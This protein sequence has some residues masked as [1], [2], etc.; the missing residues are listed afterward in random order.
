MK[1]LDSLIMQ[2]ALESK[3]P[4]GGALAVD[5]VL[6]SQY[7]TEK[8]QQH[9]L[10]EYVVDEVT[11]I[12]QFSN[13]NPVIIASG[14]LTSRPL[15]ES[16]ENFLGQE[17]LAFFDA[18]SPII[19]FDS[20]N[21]DALFKQ[22]R[23]DKG[24]GKD[25]WNIPLD[26]EQYRKFI[27]DINQAEKYSGNEE[28]EKDSL[29]KLRPF[30]GCMP[31]EDMAARGEDTP[32]FGP[33]KPKGLRDPQSGK[34][35]YAVMQLRQDDQE[36]KLWSMVGMQTRMKRHEQQRIF[37]SLPGLEKAEFVRYGTVHRNTF[38]DSPKIISPTLELRK[39][40]G[41]FFAGQITGVEGY[42]ESTASG[43][44]AGINAFRRL[45][46]ANLLVLPKETAIGGLINYV[47]DQ[48]RLH[49]QPMNVSYGLISED[50]LIENKENFKKMKKT[51]KRQLIAN[52]ALSLIHEI[53]EQI[54]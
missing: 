23:Y 50:Y 14:P 2:A 36:G 33:L 54:K 52:R 18:I 35:P 31:I 13:I 8:I 46:G 21:T 32:R 15:A 16:I 5:R 41:L 26:K 40:E 38:I 17:S 51:V 53:K 47:S 24:A 37:C 3:V 12:P 44:V 11:A 1:I 4:A 42:V 6:F 20:L 29:D 39:Y 19:T 48:T 10:I 9:S 43:L 7:I 30:E 49:F 27:S 22:S 28:V 45:N 25:Y 34:E